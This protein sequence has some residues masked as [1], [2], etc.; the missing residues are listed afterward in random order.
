MKRWTPIIFILESKPIRFCLETSF[1]LP[2]T[3]NCSMKHIATYYI[4]ISVMISFALEY[5]PRELS[6]PGVNLDQR[7]RHKLAFP[8][9]TRRRNG[10]PTCLWDEFPRQCRPLLPGRRCRTQ[11]RSGQ[12]SWLCR[13]YDHLG[14]ILPGIAHFIL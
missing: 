13:S 7:Y 9:N 5:L 10:M 1:C 2:V 3:L 6:E 12:S 11:T 4:N 8:Y 14:S